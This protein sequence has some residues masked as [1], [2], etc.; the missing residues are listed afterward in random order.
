M[1]TDKSNQPDLDL[2]LPAELANVESDLLRLPIAPS[3][4]DRDSL[5]YHAGWAA[6]VAQAESHN[7]LPFET[8]A[9]Y[10]RERSRAIVA[11]SAASAIAASILTF[12][13]TQSWHPPASITPQRT[14]VSS[15]SPVERT[16]AV[17]NVDAT[18]VAERSH[19]E[20]VVKE[21]TGVR[22]SAPVLA[23]RDTALAETFNISGDLSAG[24]Q[25]RQDGVVHPSVSSEASVRQ[26]L[27]ELLPAPSMTDQPIRTLGIPRIRTSTTTKKGESI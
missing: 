14:M 1:P 7:K 17:P 19:E 3:Q 5:L 22:W 9:T 27:Q 13:I 8:H 23:M 24:Q 16:I 15:D 12:A 25:T 21:Q 4:V 20:V 10:R 26:L 6:A 2:P 11:C 18:M